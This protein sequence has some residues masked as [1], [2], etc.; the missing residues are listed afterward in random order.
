MS[1]SPEPA[2][3]PGPRGSGP[4]A[5]EIAG[6]TLVVSGDAA[7]PLEALHRRYAGFV[8][9]GAPAAPHCQV[10][11][12]LLDGDEA[13]SDPDRAVNF[14]GGRAEFDSPGYQGLLDIPAGCGQLALYAP[15]AP[16]GL[17]YFL[18]VA[19]AL[20]AFERGGFLFHAAGLLQGERVCL[21]FGPSGSGKT[22]VA[23]LSSPGDVLNDDLVVVLPQ[24]DGWWA[25]ATPF[26]NPTQVPP[27]AGCGRLAGLFRLVQDRRVFAAPLS[28]GQA[29]AELIASVP[30]IPLDPSRGDELLARGRRLLAGV[31]AYRLHFLPDRSFWEPVVAVLA[32]RSPEGE[33]A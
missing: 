30:L 25:Y 1:A 14:R 21:F 27:G 3:A 6:L 12:A 24:A 22:T 2:P 8:L 28:L 23:R 20:L 31:P 29:L 17:D 13:A 9:P 11:F 10:R 7:G 16:E 5:V 15:Q 18:R 26:W 33:I 4:L 19:V 32:G